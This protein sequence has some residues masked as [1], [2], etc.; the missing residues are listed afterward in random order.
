MNVRLATPVDREKLS[1]LRTALWPESPITEHAAE[2]QRI[3]AGQSLSTLP[4]AIFVAETATG[5]LCGFVE[6]GLRS[7]ADGCDPSQPVGYVEGWF[8]REQDRRKGTGTALLHAAEAWA[9]STGCREM[10]SDAQLT[11]TLSQRIQESLGFEVAERA[12]LYRKKL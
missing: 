6:V 1:E 9:R 12:V 7:H 4:L 10:A 8:V 3:L 5:E 2:L 11:N